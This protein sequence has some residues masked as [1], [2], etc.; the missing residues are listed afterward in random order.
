[1]HNGIV[2]DLDEGLI[3]LLADF[4]LRQI[5]LVIVFCLNESSIENNM[6]IQLEARLR[7][8]ILRVMG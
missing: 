7:L 4:G 1:M 6:V 3:S 5:N 2:G 8:Q